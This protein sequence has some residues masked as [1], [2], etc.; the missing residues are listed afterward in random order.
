MKPTFKKSK[1]ADTGF[2][3]ANGRNKLIQTT[4]SA[5]HFLRACTSNVD[6]KGKAQ[7]RCSVA[8]CVNVFVYLIQLVLQFMLP[9]AIFYCP[10]LCSNDLVP[11]NQ[12]AWQGCKDRIGIMAH[13]TKSSQSFFFESRQNHLSISRYLWCHINRQR[14]HPIL[15]YTALPI[16]YHSHFLCINVKLDPLFQYMIWTWPM[17]K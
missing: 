3:W 5:S 15:W 4:S 2:T 10:G 9:T 8:I 14:V 11:F 13:V 7:G 1:C 16:T 17:W 12:Y 6:V